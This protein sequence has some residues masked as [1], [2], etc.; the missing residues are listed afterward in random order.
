M[1]EHRY[2]VRVTWSGNRGSGTSA[3]AAYG[4]DHEI[5]AEGKPAILA[6][7]DPHYRGDETR[8]NPEELLVASLSSCHELWYLHLCSANG[9][10][11]TAYEDDAEGVMVTDAR[12]G[13]RFTEVT[14]RPRVRVTA[15]SP[16]DKARALHE[17]AHDMCFIAQSV[18]FGVRCEPEVF[19][20]T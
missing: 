19:S 9:V 18:N 6:S 16:L 8:W 12:G 4:R 3:Y 7:S 5:S 11:V 13:G 14:L 20:E 17:E 1:S 10:V 15:S 2:R